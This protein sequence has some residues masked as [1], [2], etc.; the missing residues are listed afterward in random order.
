MTDLDELAGVIAGA[1]GRSSSA[2]PARPTWR[3]CR[4]ARIVSL[5]APT[6][7]QCAGGRGACATSCS[8][9]TPPAPAAA[10]ARAR[11]RASRA[12]VPSRGGRD[13]GGRPARHARVAHE[14]LLGTC[15]VR[16]R[17]RSCTRY[18]YVVPVVPGRGATAWDRA[19]VRLA[20]PRDRA[21]ARASPRQSRSTSSSPAPHELELCERWTGAARGATFP[22]S[23]SS[24]RAAG[25]D[26]RAAPSRR[27]A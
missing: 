17:P 12:W 24:T 25:P 22:R 7:R 20:R 10:P 1:S 26:R 15:T 6:V 9:P 5:F 18:D 8:T 4:H 21:P 23:T 13:G 27:R 19:N 16:G 3:G 11:C 2:T 14:V